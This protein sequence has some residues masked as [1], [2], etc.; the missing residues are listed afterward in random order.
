[1]YA[2]RNLQVIRFYWLSKLHPLLKTLLQ[3]CYPQIDRLEDVDLQLDES[4]T[5]SQRCFSVPKARRRNP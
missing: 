4:S 5:V 3:I 2:G 1:M